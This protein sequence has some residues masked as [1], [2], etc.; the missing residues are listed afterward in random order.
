MA[1]FD[2]VINLGVKVTKALR[3]IERV[4]RAVNKIK[5]TTLDIKVKDQAIKKVEQTANNLTKTLRTASKVANGLS[6]FIKSFFK[7][8]SSGPVD[9]L[10]R[11][12][13]AANKETQ[14]LIKNTAGYQ[15]IL[16][17]AAKEQEYMTELARRNG[18]QQKAN[19][20]TVDALE[21]RISRLAQAQSKQ[22]ASS[23]A[24]RT[25]SERLVELTERRNIAL[26]QQESVMNRIRKAQL[27]IAEAVQR[28]IRASAASRQGSKFADFSQQAGAQTAIDKSVRRQQ[29]KLARRARSAP[30]IAEAPLML[31]SSEM[32]NASERGIKRIRAVTEQ[33][34]QE[35]DYSNQEV[36]NFIRG[37]KTGSNEAVKLP[38]IF[39]KVGQSLRVINKDL[40]KVFAKSK[41]L[42]GGRAFGTGSTTPIQGRTAALRQLAELEKRLIAEVA[43]TRAKKDLQ[44]YNTRQRRI[45]YLAELE[46]KEAK[47]VADA[48]SKRNKRLESIALG[49]G[50]PALFGGGA[51]SI[52]GSLAGSFV[53]SGFGGQ[54]LGGAIGQAVD[55]YVQSLTTLAQSLESTQGILTGLE[56]AGYK[57]SESTKG[58][59][60]SYQEAG[61]EAEAYQLAIEEI[62]RV[63]GPDGASILSDYR[64]ETENLSDEFSKAKAAL[65]AELIPALT[66]TIRL[67]L[68]L[69]QAF[70]ALAES[71]LFKFIQGAAGQALNIAGPVGGAV[72][73]AE[74]VFQGLSTLGTPSGDV[75]MPDEQRKKLEQI[76]QD[77]I[78]D[79]IEAQDKLLQK[80]YERS[81]A[82]R[83]TNE[84]LQKRID[85]AKAGTDLAD[86]NVYLARQDVIERQFQLALQKAGNN[87]EVKK[88]AILTKNLAL[89][90]LQNQRT[91][92]LTKGSAGGAAPKSKELQLQ[93][94]IL[95]EKIKQ[96][97]LDT[98]FEKLSVGRIAA[99]EM[100]L[101]KLSTRLARETEIIELRRQAELENNKVAGDVGLINEKYNEQLNTLKEM[102]GLR[103]IELQQLAAKLKL[104]QELTLLEDA[105]TK[106]A[107]LR[108]KDNNIAQLGLQLANP[109]GGDQFEQEMLMLKQ[110]AE[111]NEQRIQQQEKLTKLEEERSVAAIGGEEFNTL[112]T[113]IEQQK[114]Y[115]SDLEKRTLLENEVEM[116]ILKQQQTLEK[117]QPFTN[118]LAQGLTN[119]FTAL[120]DGSKSVEE[121]FAD[122]L[123]GMGQALIQQASTMIAQYIALGIARMFA[124]GGNSPGTFNPT[125]LGA[126]FPSLTGKAA[127][128]PVNANQPYV[129]GEIGP[130]LFVPNQSGTIVTNDRLIKAMEGAF[131]PGVSGNNNADF[132]AAAAAMTTGSSQAFTESGEAMEMA[133]ATRSA[134][135]AAAAEASTMQ[136]AEAYFSSGSSTVSFDTYRVGEMDV[137]SREDA[138][139]IGQ[140]SARQ[141]EANVFKGLRNMPAVRGRSGVK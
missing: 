91:S 77:K 131:I 49:V 38:T 36:D 80:E 122:M 98:K 30:P 139:R 63:L 136:S 5:D 92:A 137:V 90:N 60:E 88:T 57:V 105:Q 85:A 76:N 4:E 55:Q 69:K 102:L 10:V 12:L 24:F 114:I 33:L 109:F 52:G 23:Q 25:I 41:R 72:K 127:G 66:G 8:F 118:A 61:L 111:L 28:N 48:R 130:E 119:M 17:I 128:G 107:S 68:G 96:D 11:A 56:E 42:A 64:I 117:L 50:F 134:N 39:D 104:Q 58:V 14:F 84:V 133:M 16:R 20:D 101:E 99:T 54:I 116:A 27:D 29:E 35:L 44:S 74:A 103:Q 1:N 83:A 59:I 75:V 140:Q 31:P 113:L 21:R 15:K 82:A 71:P 7:S 47:K 121:A 100:E 86:K 19:K 79:E 138:I 141:A 32:L 53:G 3:D 78:A 34:G 129:V 26:R 89:L 112:N 45:R 40:D 87:E 97:A 62:N 123:K 6:I 94:Q 108:A 9:E 46:D 126:G 135:V 70:D 110:S 65:D 115:M 73:N 13:Q 120:V 81:D 2:A 67:I 95:R 51:G 125:P 132:D 124:F 93:Q 37:L 106:A 22:N 43:A 18:I